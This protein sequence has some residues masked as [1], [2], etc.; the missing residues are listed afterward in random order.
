LKP[1]PSARPGGGETQAG[2]STGPP[3][4]PPASRGPVARSLRST[5]LTCT[6]AMDSVV[7][8]TG[9]RGSQVGTLTLAERGGRVAGVGGVRKPRLGPSEGSACRP[10]R[11]ARGLPFSCSRR[12]EPGPACH[13]GRGRATA[14]PTRLVGGVAPAPRRFLVR[15]R[16]FRPTT[17]KMT[18]AKYAVPGRRLEG[19]PCNRCEK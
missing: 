12:A 10:E 5:A 17:A 7:G 9:P 3:G 13:R 4:R 11:G 18:L 8:G 1:G 16:A 19:N 6:P 15:R 2:L 14:P